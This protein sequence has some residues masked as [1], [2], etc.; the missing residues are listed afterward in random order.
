MLVV[1]VDVGG[2]RIFIQV[3]DL[4]ISNAA[5]ANRAGPK[6]RTGAEAVTRIPSLATTYDALKEMLAGLAGAIGSQIKAMDADELTLEAKIGFTGKVTPVPFLA[7]AESD[8]S[9]C[10]T[11]TWKRKGDK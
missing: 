2:E 4:E 9:L 11:L 7:S 1:P 6:Q 3:R 8:A 5:P 10:V